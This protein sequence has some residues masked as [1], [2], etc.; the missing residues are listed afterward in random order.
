MTRGKFISLEGC[1]GAGKSTNLKIIEKFLEDRGV[2]ILVTREPGGTPLAEDLRSLLLEPRDENVDPLSETLMIF[3]ARAQHVT[4]IIEPAL[5]KG[6]WVICD[7]FTDATRAY[8]GGGRGVDKNAIELL[9]ELVHPDIEPDLT[10]FLDLPVDIALQRIQGRALDRFEQ[11]QVAFFE[12]VRLKYLELASDKAR[13]RLIQ[14]DQK[15]DVVA[16]EVIKELRK[17]IGGQE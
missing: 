2:D 4:N 10:I 14:A 3:A 9:V 12:R 8:Q 16:Q 6:Q 13:I 7:R 11:E 15:P 1:E 5:I 17:F